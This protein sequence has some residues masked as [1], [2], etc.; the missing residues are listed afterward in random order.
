MGLGG[1]AGDGGRVVYRRVI[2]SSITA[3]L[4]KENTGADE[5]GRGVG[6]VNQTKPPPASNTR[7]SREIPIS[8]LGESAFS[9]FS[10]LT[11]FPYATNH[12]YIIVDPP[13][14]R[15]RKNHTRVLKFL[16]SVKASRPLVAR[17]VAQPECLDAIVACLFVDGPQESLRGA[18]SVPGALEVE[19]IQKRG[20][21]ECERWREPGRARSVKMSPW[22][23]RQ[24][25]SHPMW[26]RGAPSALASLCQELGKHGV[27]HGACSHGGLAGL[28][29][30]GGTQAA[31]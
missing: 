13:C 9:A 28:G 8:C 18:G 29:D 4:A 1:A 2:V 20:M 21:W 17:M 19:A 10:V 14:Q 15:E 24:V 7:I 6:A 26:W 11:Y 5:V 22:Q 31:F 12:N 3:V 16:A 25:R 27:S 30:I 23:G